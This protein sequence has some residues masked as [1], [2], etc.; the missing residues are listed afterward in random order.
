MKNIGLPYKWC[1][2]LCGLFFDNKLDRQGMIATSMVNTKPHLNEEESLDDNMIVDDEKSER[3]EDENT[4][5]SNYLNDT[6]I[7]E[8]II[9]RLKS[10]FKA[11]ITLQEAITS[12]SKNLYFE[13]LISEEDL[14]VI[15]CLCRSIFFKF[16]N[17]V[18]EHE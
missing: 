13:K 4:M 17:L 2:I 8:Q 10:R 12:L 6:K 7:F 9:N 15:K 16:L 18:L 5:P 11:K 3:T 14:F 1:Q